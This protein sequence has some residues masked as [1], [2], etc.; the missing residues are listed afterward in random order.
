[1]AKDATPKVFPYQHGPFEVTSSQPVYKTPWIQVREDKVIRPGGSAGIFGIVEMVPGSSILPFE[2]GYVWLVK[3]FKYGIGRESLEVISG[4]IDGTESPL[5][6]AQ[7]ELAEEIGATG[8][9]WLNFGF[10]D[11]FTTVINC[12]NHL[13]L[14]QGLTWGD[15]H[16]D[17][18]E[19]LHTVKLKFTDVLEM[20]EKSEITHGASVA[21]IYKTAKFL[22]LL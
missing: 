5:Q 11:P 10:I 14:V 3:E 17:A 9:E 21:L 15:T 4:A 22:K 8:S 19:V 20:V 6:A 7:R 18:G 12:P 16:S 1:M 2:D 13:F